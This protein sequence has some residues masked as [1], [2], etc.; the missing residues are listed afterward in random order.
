MVEPNSF[1][2]ARSLSNYGNVL[3]RQGR[4][5]EAEE[6]IDSSLN[7]AKSLEIPMGII[8][9]KINLA[10]TRCI[11]RRLNYWYCLLIIIHSP[12]IIFQLGI[13]YT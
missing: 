7:I 6:A 1:P 2:A 8:I 11:I 13:Q 5:A 9:N 12:F 3:R 4:L 10:K